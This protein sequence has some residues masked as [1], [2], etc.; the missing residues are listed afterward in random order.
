MKRK[1]IEVKARRFFEVTLEVSIEANLADE[2]DDAI[3]EG[4]IMTASSLQDAIGRGIYE[5]MV[6]NVK[7]IESQA[8]Q[9]LSKPP[10]K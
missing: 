3:Y 5:V 7:V 9:I 6:D 10:K 8:P 2:L 4:T 1:I